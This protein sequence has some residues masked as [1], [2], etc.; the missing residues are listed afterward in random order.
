MQ[1]KHQHNEGTEEWWK[2]EKRKVKEKDIKSV[3]FLDYRFRDRIK[4]YI[5]K[6]IRTFYKVFIHINQEILKGKKIRIV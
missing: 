1:R 4:T 6:Q 2:D 5:Y 3:I